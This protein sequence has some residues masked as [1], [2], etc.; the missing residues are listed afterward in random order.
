MPFSKSRL[1]MEIANINAPPLQEPSFPEHRFSTFPLLN[2][3]EATRRV[4]GR[5]AFIIFLL[6]LLVPRWSIEPP[7]CL[8]KH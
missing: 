7:M 8:K 3:T 5:V 2:I 1:V 4:I 6:L